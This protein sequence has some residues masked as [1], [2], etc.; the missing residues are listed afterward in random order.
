MEIYVK[1]KRVSSMKFIGKGGEAEVFDIGGGL[2]LKLF[3]PPDH[4]DYDLSLPEQK[5]ASRRIAEHQQKLPMF[6]KNLP[7]R[8]MAPQDLALDK[9]GKNIVGYT[10]RYLAGT[11]TILRYGEAGF[12]KKISGDLVVRIFQ[13]LYKTVA[14]LHASAA[15]IGDFN[16]LNVLV[17]NG[18]ANLVDADSFQFGK[19]LTKGFTE[20]FV[21]PLL[22]ASQTPLLLIRPHNKNSDWYA[23]AVMFLQTL[24]AVDPYGG[25]YKPKKASSRILH[26]SRVLRRITVFHPEVMYPKPAIPYQ[27]LPDEL[28]HQFHLIFEKDW[29]GAFPEKSIN[30]VRWTKCVSC[31]TEHARPLCPNCRTAH[32]SIVRQATVVRGK[33]IASAIF[34]TRGSIVFAAAQ[35]G[36]LLWLFYENGRF[37]R[38]DGAVVAESDLDPELRFRI[39]GSKT[40]I[41]KNNLLA[42]FDRSKKSEIL[43][44]D[45]F[46]NIPVFD[47]NEKDIFRLQ[48][49][50]ILKS[51]QWGDEYLGQGVADQTIFWTGIN[52]GFGWYEASRL[53]A[54]FIFDLEQTQVNDNVKI[55]FPK[56]KVIDSAA[57]MSG[58]RI[59]FF[60]ASLEAGKIINRAWVIKPDGTAEAEAQAE[61]GDGSWLSELRGKCAIGKILLAATDDGIVRLEADAGKIIKTKEFPD[62]EPFVSAESHLFPGQD[63]LYAVD[64]K[65]IRLLKMI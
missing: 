58:E 7:E 47:A 11:E 24:L 55:V 31:G 23:F 61:R 50:R 35:K 37:R 49:G 33:V 46:K 17:K 51:G 28:L 3:K 36:K 44:I 27:T 18:Q 10:M 64:E 9:S 13:D 2:A 38:E 5:A 56:G 14:M 1:G 63:G 32:P 40:L 8:V 30:D 48:N 53:R 6:P 12:R 34:K 42:V 60:I 59:W 41:G 62:T 43:T 29:R 39:M 52:F 26:N 21:D 57:A 65:E 20:K 15:V 45:A 19:F 16:D 22:C 25:I 54:A 4:P